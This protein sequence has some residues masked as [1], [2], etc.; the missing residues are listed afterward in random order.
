MLIIRS[1]RLGYNKFATKD[2]LKMFLMIDGD[3]VVD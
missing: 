1:I 2:L 3:V